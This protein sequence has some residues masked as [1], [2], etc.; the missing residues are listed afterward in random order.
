[1]SQRRRDQ[2]SLFGDA[3]RP[4]DAGAP[5]ERFARAIIPAPPLA[6]PPGEDATDSGPPGSSRASAYTVS[7]LNEA[8]RLALQRALGSLW[9]TGEIANWRSSASGH[10]YFTLRDRSGQLACVMFQGDAARL[11][12]EPDDGLEVFAFGEVSLYP[13][14]GSYEFI[15]RSIEPKGEGLWRLAFE[16]LRRKLAAEGLLDPRRKRALPRYPSTVGVVTSRRGAAVR[17]VV[18]VIGRRAP[19]VRVVLSHCAVQ[20]DAAPAE[21]CHALEALGR[22]PGIDVIV[23]TRG[24]GSV[25]DLGAFNDESVARAV[26]ASPVPVVSAVGHEVDMTMC[27]LVADLRAATPSAAAE[28]VVPDGE[29]I[30][31]GLERARGLLANR[32]R[33]HAGRGEER[34]RRL[35]ERLLRGLDRRF[36]GWA[37]E[38]RSH[39]GRLDALSPLETLRRGYAVP[40]GASGDVLRSVSAFEVG[41]RFRLR[42]LDGSVGCEARDVARLDEEE[43]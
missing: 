19:W 1:M 21:I 32:L 29:E 12:A 18:S 10:R 23:L 6:P 41:E 13:P 36:D 33:R 35:E 9:V 11:P 20:G 43:P 22:L 42:V 17:D 8:S 5:A 39:A 28:M 14:R 4:D 26:A 24:G 27:D 31:R 2:F 34:T 30:R 25:E 40:L 38:L 16:R 15:V 3:G 37:A 7:S